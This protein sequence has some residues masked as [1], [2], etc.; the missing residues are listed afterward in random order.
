V[1]FDDSSNPHVA[2]V[3]RFLRNSLSPALRELDLSSYRKRGRGVLYRL[4]RWFGRIQLC[5]FRRVA[6]VERA[7]NSAFH[8]F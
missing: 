7:W 6:P 1:V 4:A 2:K 5:G 3:L 8:S